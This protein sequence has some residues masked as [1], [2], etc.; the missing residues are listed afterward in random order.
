MRRISIVLFLVL[1]SL[2][3]HAQISTQKGW[4]K[5]GVREFTEPDRTRILKFLDEARKKSDTIAKTLATHDG[6]GAKILIPDD[7]MPRWTAAADAIAA[8][9]ELHLEYRNQAY[10][11]TTAGGVEHGTSRAWYALVPAPPEIART[12]VS[13]IVAATP[14]DHAGAVEGIDVNTYPD[15]PTWLL[16]VDAAMEPPH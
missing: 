9:P 3:A 16:R 15:V 8:H 2:A 10:E 1:L 13:I 14:K 7:I 11:E 4:L 12:F 6:L 5:S